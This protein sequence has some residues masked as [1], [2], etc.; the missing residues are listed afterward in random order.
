VNIMATIYKR[1]ILKPIPE[2]AT[3]TERK[4]RR[5]ATWQDP[6]TRK[7]RSAPLNTKGSKR[8]PAGSCIVVHRDTWDVAY[9]NERGRRRWKATGTPDKATAER[10]AARLVDAVAQRRAKLIDPHSEVIA[11]ESQRTI[12]AQ[13][14]DY[15]AKLAAANRTA[16]HIGTTKRFIRAIAAWAEWTTVADITADGVN[17]YAGERRAS[18]YS[19]RS[20]QACLTAVKGFTRWLA[21]NQKLPRDPLA[22]V[23]K[24]DPKSDRRKERRMLL[25]EE[26]LWLRAVT[27]AGPARYG[28]SPS[29]RVLLYATAI[30][31]GLRSGELRS[32]T[33]GKLFLDM[34]PPFVTC[35]ARAAKNRQDARQYIDTDLA[36]D[37]RGHIGTKAPGAAVFAMPEGSEMANMLREDLTDARAAWLKAA[38]H[39][40][41]EYTRR[42]QSD[43]LTAKNHE[44][45]VLDFHGLRHTCGAWLA[46]DGAHPKAVQSVMRHSSITLT[47][48]TYGHLF[49]GQEAETV[50]RLS[51]MLTETPRELRATGSMDAQPLPDAARPTDRPTVT[52]PAVK[53]RMRSG[54]SSMP[55]RSCPRAS[56]KPSSAT[57][58]TWPGCPQLAGQPS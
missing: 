19:A 36:R 16:K 13:L 45:E 27:A 55:W 53:V 56:D 32:L 40:P 18:G 2:G 46:M 26:W 28:M 44:G 58:K 52:R 30:Q 6:D 50:A 7:N 12:E 43:F 17:G 34:K 23:T 47:M 31:T 48:D 39:D 25:P 22:S 9:F 8:H 1:P 41:E 5:V 33:R 4:G 57:F 11:R 42:V 3:I 21:V 38:E 15:E 14:A 51:G 54:P 29:E 20:I 37:L 35:K 24:P 10:I 49:P